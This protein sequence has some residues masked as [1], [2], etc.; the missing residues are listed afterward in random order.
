[1]DSGIDPSKVQ[2]KC[3]SFV[4]LVGD[5]PHFFYVFR[6]KSKLDILV[7]LC[8]ATALSSS[9]TDS[10]T[11]T[12]AE[13]RDVTG[14][15]RAQVQMSLR[16]LERGGFL[17][18][19][20]SKRHCTYVQTVIVFDHSWSQTTEQ[21][22]SKSDRF[23][24][25]LPGDTTSRIPLPSLLPTCLPTAGARAREG[26]KAGRQVVLR[27]QKLFGPRWHVNYLSRLAERCLAAVPERSDADL[28]PFATA[29][30]PATVGARC[31]PALALDPTEFRAWSRSDQRSA[32]RA[33]PKAIGPVAT[34]PPG[35]GAR[36][37]LEALRAKQKP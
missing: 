26:R 20:R 27:L 10:V 36:R 5:I 17:R 32:R 6:L 13:I 2:G 3:G 21:T 31:P 34:I 23:R 19:I 1:M 22:T 16:R 8:L 30:L 4:H 18:R 25:L 37:V 24:S 29:R 35:Q 12:A 11:T 14:G 7:F 15:S 9:E 28:L 33:P